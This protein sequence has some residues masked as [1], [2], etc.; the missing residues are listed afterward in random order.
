MLIDDNVIDLFLNKK[1]IEAHKLANKT[2]KFEDSHEAFQY[3]HSASAADWP[4]LIL[5]D[6][7]MPIM[8]GFEFLE[9]YNT[10]PIENRE[11]TNI[12][13]LSSSI[14]MS[15]NEKV[16]KYPSVIAFLTKP[17]NITELVQLLKDKGIIKP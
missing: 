8:D 14:L 17:L 13:M 6:I 15:D 4:N 16:L 3:L 11:K 7:H 9:L 5:L 10:L 1:F 2:T 12:I